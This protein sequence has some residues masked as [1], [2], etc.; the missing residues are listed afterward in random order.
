ML[1]AAA[2]LL[3]ASRLSAGFAEWYARHIY[4]LFPATLGRLLSPLPFSLSELLL[5]LAL[6]SLLPLIFVSLR[7]LRRSLPLRGLLR[8]LLFTLSLLLLLFTLTAGVNYSR[9]SFAAAA[10]LSPAPAEAERLTAL[11]QLLIADIGANA[12]LLALDAEGCARVSAEDIADCRRAMAELRESYPS[13]APAIVRP[14][15]AAYSQLLSHLHLSGI[16]SP[17][18]VEAHYNVL[19]PD[20]AQPYSV[21]HELAH[22]MGYMR[23]QDAGFIAYLACAHSGR[24]AL[25]YS[26]AMGALNY[27]IN[28][29]YAALPPDD[30]Y[31][32]LAGLPEQ[33]HRDL[34]A[35]RG[36]WA[37]YQG[38]A[39]EVSQK[40]NDAYL[41]L[42]AQQAGVQSYGQM[43]DLL[44]AYYGDQL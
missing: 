36:F 29:C 5:A 27:V 42:N 35:S 43:V 4:P 22:S 30:Y 38:R 23:E 12:P 32:L 8:G 15:P 24:P 25:R 9:P 18:T 2:L 37:K 17:F 34:A 26:G 39:A 14:K 28:A 7:R 13:L 10:G 21:C 1:G 6:I 44:L 20:Y 41:R 11:Y 40:T 19:M 3:L 16:F 33:A 31:V